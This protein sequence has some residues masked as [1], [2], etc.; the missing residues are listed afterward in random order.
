MDPDQELRNKLRKLQ[1]IGRRNSIDQEELESRVARLKG[2]DPS[3]Y[4]APPITV[5]QPPDTRTDVEKADAL[6]SQLLEENSIDRHVEPPPLNRRMSKDEELEERLNKLK[7]HVIK[8]GETHT[9][10]VDSEEETEKIV[11]KLLS[12]AKLPEIPG[13]GDDEDEVIPISDEVEDTDDDILTWCVICNEDARLKCLDCD[14]DIYCL[15]CFRL[16]E[17]NGG[18][19]G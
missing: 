17:K 4:S 12:E 2:I 8:L 13:D 7:G 19:V 10:E 18:T 9:M 11:E 3:K 5:Y 14:G 1:S 15:E 6:L 16:V